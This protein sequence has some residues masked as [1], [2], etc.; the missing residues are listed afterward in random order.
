MAQCTI[1]ATSTFGLESVVAL[2][3]KALGYELL[4]LEN[5]KVS[6]KG[7]ERDIARCNIRLRTADRVLIKVAEFPAMD[8]EE[9]FQGTMKVGWEEI[10]PLTGK[11]HIVGKSVKSQLF[12]VKDCQAIV[13]RAVVEAMKRKYR[14][15]W[16]EESGPVYKIEISMLKDMATLTM[17]TSGPG[18]HK[19]GYRV[20][21]GEAP[22]RETIA[23][24][25][26]ML[27]RWTPDRILVDPMCGSGTIA[28]EAALMGKNIAPG[29]KRSFISEE[30]PQM[31]KDIWEEAR[32]EAQS[33]I[34]DMEFRILASDNDGEVLKKARANALQAG[35]ADYV[36]FQKLPVEEFRSR[37]K[38]G[39]IVC[40]PPYGER[41]GESREIERL[42]RTMGNVFQGLDSWSFFM[43]AAHP[44]FQKFFGKRADKNRK[45][46]NGGIKCYLYQY[47]G[48]LPKRHS[49]L[50]SSYPSEAEGSETT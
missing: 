46:F 5:G 28:I 15:E 39:C 7:S 13:K 42:Y 21:A 40:N 10:I 43:F 36:A 3:L 25:L 17:D 50:T 32:E 6:F 18:L 44:Y 34:K 22:L 37:K 38:Y 14:T 29:L 12:S 48:P 35:V 41:L 45:I 27:S 9:L 1:I 8:F 19:R 49:Y 33:Q 31:P 2:E 4:T 26:V 20:D 16:F 30:W 11:M 24:A 47:L 23:A